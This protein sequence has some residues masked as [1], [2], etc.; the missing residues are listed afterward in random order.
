MKKILKGQL[1]AN[2]SNSNFDLI[3]SL[4]TSFLEKV[5]FK[6]CKFVLGIGKKSV[7]I[8]QYPLNVYIKLQVLKYMARISNKDNNPLLLDAYSLSKT[9]HLNGTYSWYT[10][11]ENILNTKSLKKTLLKNYENMFFEK[12]RSFNINNKL[13]LYS[14]IKT[15]Y[16][17]EPF[18]EN[19][20]FENRKLIVKM[21]I[22]DHVL[23]IE[24]GRYNKINR[25]QRMCRQCHLNVIE[26]EEHFFFHCQKKPNY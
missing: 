4:D 14:K 25:E 1:R 24:R 5:N 19:S 16:I 7:N 6:F 13:F 18:I 11:A 15:N 10:F 17:I 23:E 20:N 2:K 9:V 3:D 26:D 22:S 8:S 12:L 21:R